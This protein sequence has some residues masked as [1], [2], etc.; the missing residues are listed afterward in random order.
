MIGS[1]F[2]AVLGLGLYKKKKVGSFYGLRYLGIFT[3]L[4]ILHIWDDIL[5]TT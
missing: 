2:A 3:T 5:A 1:Y 4:Y